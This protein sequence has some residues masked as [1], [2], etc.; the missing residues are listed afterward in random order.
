MLPDV[1]WAIMS[2]KT[3]GYQYGGNVDI[4]E[5][6][7]GTYCHVPAYFDGF[8][9]SEQGCCVPGNCTGKLQ[10]FLTVL[11]CFLLLFFLKVLYPF[12]SFVVFF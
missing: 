2:G 12:T 9:V 5:Y 1:E 6:L 11:C 3:A 7:Y 4:C 8:V 10:I